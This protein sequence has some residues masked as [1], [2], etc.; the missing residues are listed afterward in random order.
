[1]KGKSRAIIL[2]IGFWEL[3][4]ISQDLGDVALDPLV[5][6]QLA[7]QHSAV[8]RR[9]QLLFQAVGALLA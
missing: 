2:A 4:F 5:V 1:M 6:H 7:H 8:A 3:A 9:A